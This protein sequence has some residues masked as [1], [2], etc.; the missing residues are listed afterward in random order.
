MLPVSVAATF[1]LVIT[2]GVVDHA[3]PEQVSA[4]APPV[5]ATHFVHTPCVYVNPGGQ[6][7]CPP[8]VLPPEFP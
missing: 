8:G 3:G 4:P 2:A 5:S 6:W 1:L 7:R